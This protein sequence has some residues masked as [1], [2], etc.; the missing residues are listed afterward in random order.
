MEIANSTWSAVRFKNAVR[1][2]CFYFSF[3]C[4]KEGQ[5]LEGEYLVNLDQVGKNLRETRHQ[6]A[7]KLCQFNLLFRLL[8]SNRPRLVLIIF[9]TN[10]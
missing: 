4:D 8:Q 3:L 5:F 2:C 10:S 6:T 9:L 1:C 7:I